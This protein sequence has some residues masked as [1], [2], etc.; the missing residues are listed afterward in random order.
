MADLIRING[1]AFDHSSV[2]IKIAGRRL[3]QVKELKYSQKRTRS[4]VPGN[5]KSQR[6]VAR[7]SG[8]YEIDK[9]TI[10]TTRHEARAI[11]DLFASK[12]HDGESYGDPELPLVVQYVERGLPPIVDSFVKC[13]LESDAGGT[14]YGP[15]ALMEDVVLDPMHMK[16]NGKHLYASDT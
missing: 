9:I 12:S 10:T 3:R 2:S 15:D 7:T 13:S 1:K 16:R 14:S 11:R 6:A 5:N 4:K 8:N